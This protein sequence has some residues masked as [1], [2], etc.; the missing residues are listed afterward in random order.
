MAKSQNQPPK[1]ET[2]GEKDDRKSG[3]GLCTLIF[4]GAY[5]AILSIL[6]LHVLIVVWP[7]ADG[8]DSR[9]V[10]FGFIKLAGGGEVGLILIAALC[11]A[12]GSL[13]HAMTSFT[14]Y[15]GNR[16]FVSTWV[17]W[18]ILRPFIGMPLALIFY[19]VVRGGFFTLAA[20][21]N[22]VSP[23][24][25]AGVAGL[26]GMFSKQAIDKLRELF[27]Q[28]FKTDKPDPRTDKLED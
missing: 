7:G 1:T 21:T 10:L 14:S 19:F 5:F 26:V 20:D 18:F 24:G 23:F 25:I 28:L 4:F 11:G 8:A 9:R 12:L 22:A 15:V 3:A 16:R 27:E 13:V 2:P 17:L 6:I